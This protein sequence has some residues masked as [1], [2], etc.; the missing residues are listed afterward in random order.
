MP[1]NLSRAFK[2]YLT[3]VY[4]Q[5]QKNE[6]LEE[7]KVLFKAIKEEKI[8]IKAKSKASTNF[9]AIKSHSK[10]SRGVAP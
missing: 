3:V 8:Y 2:T 7:D 1:N 5:M 9:A 10:P 6:Q 4:N